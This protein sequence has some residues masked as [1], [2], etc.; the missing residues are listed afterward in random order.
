MG[1]IP[2]TGNAVVQSTEVGT[3]YLVKSTVTVNDLA[4]I[5]GATINLWNSVTISTAAANTNLAATGLVDGTYKVYA[6]DAEGNLSTA[7]NN[8][9]TIDTMAPSA[10]TTGSIVTQGPPVVAG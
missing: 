8:S 9:V 10:F 3:A 4:S 7:S 1:T 2:N 5:T 6:V